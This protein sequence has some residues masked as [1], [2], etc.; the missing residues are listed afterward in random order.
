MSLAPAYRYRARVLAVH[1]GDTFTVRIDLGFRAG[2]EL[3][4]RLADVDAPELRDAGGTDARDYLRE[5][6]LDRTVTVTTRKTR[7]GADVRSFVRYVADV[8]LPAGL[9]LEL[10]VADALV[11]SGHARRVRN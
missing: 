3:E 8:E 2:L 10:D 7:A 11:E 9:E 1:D 4:L 5:L 6:I